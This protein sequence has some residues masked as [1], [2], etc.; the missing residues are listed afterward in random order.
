MTEVTP[1]A[2]AAICLQSEL[3]IILITTMDLETFVKGHHVYKEIWTP[4]HD[5]E[6]EV[7]TEPENLKD[8][9]AV[10]VKKNH[11]IVGHLKKG[12]TGIFE[13]TII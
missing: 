13:K 4:K 11:K 7:S 12:A 3:P 6:L 9:F 8:K 1:E 5:E 10:C 2:T